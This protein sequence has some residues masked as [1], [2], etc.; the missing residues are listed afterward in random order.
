[1]ADLLPDRLDRDYEQG[2]VLFSGG[3]DSA[4]A[5]V[6]L[7]ERC[8]KVTLL[9]FDPGYVF[10][11]ENSRVHADLLRERYGADRVEHVIRPIG[12][13]VR[14]ILF[15]DVKRDLREYGF[16][17]TALVCMGC[18]LSMHTAALIHNLEHGIP[19]LADGSIEKQDAI[20]EQRRSVLAENRA[21]YFRDYGVL[22][23]QPIYGEARSD[24]R[25]FEKG[26]APKRGLKKQFIFFD[27]Q[28]TCVFGVPA[29]VY[30]RMFYKP[31]M[32]DFTDVESVAYCRER[33]PKMRGEIEAYFARTGQDLPALVARLRAQHPPATGTA[34]DTEARDAAR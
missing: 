18:R 4:L 11:V 28:A 21:L 3:T 9:T 30:A 25:L 33:H 16:D 23:V 5:A 19:V 2:S 24:E 15:G 10:F 6:H 27:T 1:M 20:P 14:K 26:I 7:L 34:T 13:L 17:M 31:L 8:R 32:G 22:H 12:E 29:D